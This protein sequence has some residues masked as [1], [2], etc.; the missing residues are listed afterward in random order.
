MRY[1]V[2]AL[3][4][5]SSVPS[6]GLGQGQTACAPADSVSQ[7]LITKLKRLMQ[8]TSGRVALA[9]AMAG[10]PQVD[11]AT[12]VLVTDCDLCAKAERAYTSEVD[13]N[14]P[15]SSKVHVVRVG[16]VYV[17]SD[18]QRRAGEFSVEV[19]MDAAFRVLSKHLG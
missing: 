17:V 12:I 10:I 18:P 16:S 13:A 11:A 4:A 9:R 8:A 5:L 15:T 7:Y 2:I 3:I 19:V 1:M 6:A 14:P